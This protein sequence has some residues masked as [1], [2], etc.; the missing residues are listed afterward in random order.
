MLVSHEDEFGLE[1]ILELDL[2]VGQDL[3]SAFADLAVNLRHVHLLSFEDVVDLG[4]TLDHADDGDVL[5]NLGDQGRH[6]EPAVHEQ[7]LGLDAGFQS[8]F[9]HGFNQFRGLG[10]SLLAPPCAA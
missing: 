10:H 6:G 4:R 1:A 9:D 2:G 8:A 5:A 3:G 7:E